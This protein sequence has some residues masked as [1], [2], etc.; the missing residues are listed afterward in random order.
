[1]ALSGDRSFVGFGFG[2]IQAGLFLYEAYR[3]GSFR[4]LTVAEVVP[5]TVARLRES[6][7]Q[8]SVNIA[9]RDCVR[10]EQV[11]P[12]QA[13]N[14]EDAA[15]RRVLI[16]AVASA[17]EIATALPSVR[18]YASSSAGSV[19]RILAEGLLQKVTLDGPPV[20]IYAA[21]NHNRAAELL[22]EAVLGALPP[23][24]RAAVCKRVA[25]VNT[26]IGKMSGVVTDAQQV[27][28]QGMACVTPGD[29]RAFLVE[30]FN[31]ILISRPL[32]TG[33]GSVP[34]FRRGIQV[35]EEKLDLLPFEE[36]KLYGHNSTH[37]VA[38]YL[39]MILGVEQITDLGKQAGVIDFLR[40]AFV[41]ESGEALIRKHTGVDRLFTRAGYREYADDLLERMTNPFL[42]DTVDRVGRDP[43][44]K[45]EWDDRLVGTIRT[46][47]SQ[48]I[49]APRYS[50]GAAAALNALHPSTLRSATDLRGV[51][52]PLWEKSSPDP[53]EMAAVIAAIET[54]LRKLWR[55]R[56]AGFPNLEAFAGER[57][58]NA[59]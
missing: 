28:K 32:S 4:S 18:F 47:L 42:G 25:F 54:G 53:V 23:G 16:H 37:A 11:G 15:D 45:L 41:E 50:I 6:G 30:E 1:M 49:P 36:A 35:F 14:P 20:I 21:E 33:H 38:A 40:A 56:D 9:F 5:E 22:E 52:L 8:Y 13:M 24:C 7:G 26:V 48:G 34:D 10:A 2:A 44:R 58:A 51:L 46:A 19:H 31:R 3:S 57:S 27:A 12:I 29:G 17:S 43:A 55:W 39:G 59:S